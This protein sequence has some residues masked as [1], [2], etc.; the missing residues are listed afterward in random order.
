MTIRN[1]RCFRDFTVDSLGQ[2]N[3]VSGKNSVGKTAFLEAIFLLAGAENISLVVKISALRGIEVVGGSLE[4]VLDLL[5]SPLFH[6][7]Q[8][9]R[10]I[11]IIG[12]LRTEGA[13]SVGLRLVPVAAQKVDLDGSAL[14]VRTRPGDLSSQNLELTYSAPQREPA[15]FEMGFI[16]GD[17]KIRPRPTPPPF[18]GYYF[19]A[20]GSL[21]Q[22]DAELLGRLI[23]SKEPFADDLVEILRVVE[24][25]LQRIEAVPTRAV[26][27]LWGDIGLDQLLPL[28]LMGD[29][30]TRLTAILLRIANSA[31]GV[32]L[33]D[34]IE[35]GFHHSIHRDVWRA[36]YRAAEIFQTQ[37]FVTT[38]SYECLAA[39]H[40]VSQESFA[41]D[42]RFYRLDR[43]DGQIRPVLFDRE[44]LETALESSMEVR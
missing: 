20:R 1:F 31:R 14:D 43:I 16:D 8:S 10:K 18:P 40:E 39:A 25:R 6:E 3:L 29:G 9:D 19:T 44:M 7:L 27:Q 13:H 34:E 32:V 26:S 28:S 12:Q 21:G 4:S 11:E 24:N 15:T 23:K 42:S 17:L 22:E 41:Y 36:I 38:H 37:V 33:V 5:W 35:N 30:L 2:V